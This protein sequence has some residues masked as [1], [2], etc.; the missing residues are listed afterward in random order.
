MEC[1]FFLTEISRLV[2][3]ITKFWSNRRTL[4]KCSWVLRKLVYK[5]LW[6]GSARPKRC[7]NNR[8][9]CF[10]LNAIIHYYSNVF[11][12]EVVYFWVALTCWI[13]RVPTS[14]I[15]IKIWKYN[16]QWCNVCTWSK[17][18][19][20]A[21]HWGFYLLHR[22]FFWRSPLSIKVPACDRHIMIGKGRCEM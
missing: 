2:G 3:I 4:P 8:Y 5:L 1:L 14:F 10:S 13:L 16:T 9:K 21:L 18:L 15:V 12:F 17:H 22:I 11:Y 19:I 7:L 6:S 20:S